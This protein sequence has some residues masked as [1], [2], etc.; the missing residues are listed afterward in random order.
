MSVKSVDKD[1]KKL[2][3]TITAEFGAEVEQ[4]WQLW[5]DPRNLERWWGPPGYPATVVDHT[6]APGGRISYYMTSPE[7][8][9]YH[10]YIDVVALDPPHRLDIAEGFAHETGAPNDDMP[11]NTMVITFEAAGT[12]TIMTIAVQFPSQ[13][14]MEQMMAMGMDEGMTLA[15]GQIDAILAS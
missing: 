15:V 10:A 9:K 11:R 1:P 6:F 14:A 7:G 13:A 5:A 4:V 3:L 2:S 12:G 8:A